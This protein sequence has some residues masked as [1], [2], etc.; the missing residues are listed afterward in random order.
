MW[1]KD[2]RK[3]QKSLLNPKNF[4]FKRFYYKNSL[5]NKL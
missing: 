3:N 2:G 5:D 1:W 4:Y